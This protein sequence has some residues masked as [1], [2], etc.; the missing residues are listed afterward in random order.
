V[1]TRVIPSS[2]QA[3]PDLEAVQEDEDVMFLEMKPA[4]KDESDSDVL[5]AVPSVHPSFSGPNMALKDFGQE[6]KT[7][8]DALADI[9]ARGISHVVSLPELVLVGDQSSG[10]SSLMSAIAGLSLPRSSG[11]CTRCPLHIRISKAREWS[12]RVV[13]KQDYEFVPPRH[14][15]AITIDDVNQNNKFPPWKKL[16]VN[17]QARNEFK[18]VQDRFDSEELETVLHCAQVAILNPSTDFSYF[19]PS[20]KGEAPEETR[21]QQAQRV[22][23][24]ADRAEAQFS[25]NTVALE[26]KGPDL[27]DLNFYDLPGV[28]LTAKRPE[29]K[30]LERVVKNLTCEYIARPNAIILGAVPMNIDAENSYAFKLI[31]ELKAE[32]RCVGVMTKADLLPHDTA[33]SRSWLSMLHEKT[34]RI[35]LGYF[36]TSRQ[37]G[38]LEAQNKREEAFFNR[39]PM[40]DPQGSWPEDFEQFRERCGV[41]KLKAFLSG[42]LGEEFSKVSVYPPPCF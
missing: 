31:R 33:A 14:G 25:P 24:L 10:K 20:L 40:F 13:L 3:E 39:T 19:I 9:Q 34:H 27:A 1:A 30:F 41:E 21:I 11:T 16:P 4:V 38:D 22:E 23:E 37:E 6:L 15:R 32:S 28:F 17:R 42:K 2:A 35:G 26:V 36:I 18:T 7:T 29:D 5:S 8:L 12:C